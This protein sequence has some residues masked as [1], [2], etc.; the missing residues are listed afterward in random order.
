[1][2]VSYNWLQDY[3]DEKLPSPDE[4]VE[5]LTFGA[6]E[7]E[8]TEKVGEDVVIDVDVLPNRASDSLSHRGIAR[9]IAT[10]LG[11]KLKDDP[12]AR[13]TGGTPQSKLLAVDI[14]DPRRCYR[15]SA[16]VVSGVTVGPSPKWLQDRLLALGQKPINNVV[17]VGNY[18]MFD[19][20][21][22]LHAFD[23]DKL[24]EKDGAYSI[25]VRAGDKGEQMVALTGETYKLSP[26]ELVVTDGNNGK[27]IGIAGV[28]GGKVPEVDEKTTNLIIEAA[29]FN[30]V[31]VRKTSQRLKLVTDASV[32]FQNELSP[33]LTLCG[34]RDT[35]ALLSKIGA[36][37]TLEG[38]VDVYPRKRRLYKLGVS[39][40]EI[41]TLLGAD[42]KEKD[43]ER[44]LHQFGFTYERVSPIERILSHAPQLVGRPYRYGASVS[45]D[46]PDEFDCSGLVTYLFREAG[47]SIPRI[48]VDQYVYGREVAERDLKRGDV[49]FS[50]TADEQDTETFTLVASGEKAT[51]HTL[52]RT[53]VEFMP[54]TKVPKGIS[55]NGIYLGGGKVMHAAS[56]GGKGSVVIE[57]LKQSKGFEN[58]AGYRRMIE[59]DEERFVVEVPFE[60]KDLRIKEDLV[61]EIGRV[62]GYKQVKPQ[63]LPKGGGKPEVN[64]QYYYQERVRSLLAGQ[65]F[66]EV[67]TYVLRDKGEVAV[68]N[69]LASDKSRLRATLTEGM[70]EALAFNQKNKPLLGM[71]HV[72]SFEIGKVFAR[73]REYTALCIGKEAG[74]KPPL[75]EVIALLEE[76]FGVGLNST[77]DA[78]TVEFDVD[79]LIERLPQPKT[80]DTPVYWSNKREVKYKPI[81]AYPFVLR[82]I[83]VWVP[84]GT[85]GSDVLDVITRA[86]GEL[87]VGGRL[88]DTYEK[89]DRTSYAFN[90]VFQSHEKTLSDNEVN[91]AMETVT[92]T[93]EKSPQFEVR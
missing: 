37:G 49:I 64:K 59:S 54:G 63:R 44:I 18:V 25:T 90:L 45:Y 23:R 61:E 92:R 58:I 11:K 32:R 43:I 8:G 73:D 89:G 60:R 27:A 93:L 20:G 82:D 52:H 19:M 30:C 55:H 35:V 21:Q 51:K 83:A 24:A 26:D 91:K 6:F 62:Y 5:L 84:E 46:A 56:N 77:Q 3:F 47:V 81:S 22:P 15:F 9:E 42:I 86:A 75:A 29:N 2:R 41:N 76:I 88:F 7:I 13:K 17:D 71:S 53:S 87:L 14:A 40:S 34:L 70:T 79:E 16:A 74:S 67:I 66:S 78:Q 28:K 80:Y 68:A 65:G 10:L 31:S 36:G 48:S 85:S 69:P 4:L 72:K 12:L 57:Q 39:R 38:Y 1:M 33:E 50:R